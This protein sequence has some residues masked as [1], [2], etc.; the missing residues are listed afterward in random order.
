MIYNKFKKK[1]KKRS[2]TNKPKMKKWSITNKPKVEKWF[3]TNKPK[4]KKWSWPW[5]SWNVNKHIQHESSA[6]LL[7]TDKQFNIPSQHHFIDLGKSG[8]KKLIRNV[9]F[10]I[11][12]RS[13]L[14]IKN[15]WAAK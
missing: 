10:S 3:I 2:I 7:Q 13:S 12:I 5:N 4:V 14:C 6:P 9:K 1:W 11:A 15:E 8:Q